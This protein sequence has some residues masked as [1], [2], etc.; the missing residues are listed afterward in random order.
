VQKERLCFCQRKFMSICTAS[1]TSE[2]KKCKF[3]KKSSFT[4]KCMHFMFDEY[5]DCLEAQVAFKHTQ[6]S[7]EPDY[8]WI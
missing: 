7:V 6:P 5:C 1:S 2:Q 3:Y 4:D 8:K